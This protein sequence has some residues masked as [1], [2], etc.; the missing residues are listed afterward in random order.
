MCMFLL[1]TLPAILCIHLLSGCHTH[2]RFPGNTNIDYLQP[3]SLRKYNAIEIL[4]I[5][6]DEEVDPYISK[7][8]QK[9]I[10]NTIL[11]SN[12]FQVIN[13]SPRYS[14][15]M[16]NSKNTVLLESKVLQYEVGKEAP[17]G[18][19]MTTALLKIKI[20][21]LDALDRSQ[22]V[23][24]I[25][26]TIEANQPIVGLTLEHLRIALEENLKMAIYGV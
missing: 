4:P 6:F 24:E 26:C 3:L 15:Y 7:L 10:F 14:T 12:F 19:G 22:S 8:C 16:P 9:T 2:E 11:G 25:V 13:G 18:E 21:F 23:G 1:K 5:Q 20:N 17:V